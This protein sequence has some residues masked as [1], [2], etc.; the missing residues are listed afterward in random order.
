[1][2]P[3]PHSLHSAL[4]ASLEPQALGTVN[5]LA[6]TLDDAAVLDDAVDRR[7]HGRLSR[8][9]RFEELDDAGQTAVMSFGLSRMFATAPMPLVGCSG[10]LHSRPGW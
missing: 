7:D 9:A 4:R 5:D 2:G 1:V 3:N 8:L 10:L 6:L